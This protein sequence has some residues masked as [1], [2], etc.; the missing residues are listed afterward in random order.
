VSRSRR[1]GAMLA[2]LG[3]LGIAGC[4]VAWLGF[5]ED[6][7]ILIVV[8]AFLLL[9][10]GVG[11]LLRERG[12]GLTPVQ[13]QIGSWAL[14]FLVA[15]AYGLGLLVGLFGSGTSAERYGGLAMVIGGGLFAFAVIRDRKWLSRAHVANEPDK[16]P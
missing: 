4:L 5:D 15:C 3:T 8:A 6:V 14:L 1:L 9:V 2:L 16:T 11:V 12:G 7:N 13:W 10:R